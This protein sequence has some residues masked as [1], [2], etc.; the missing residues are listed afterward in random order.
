MAAPFLLV[1]EK[2]N[3]FIEEKQEFNPNH[4]LRPLS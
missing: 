4:Y 3:A 1:V 2:N